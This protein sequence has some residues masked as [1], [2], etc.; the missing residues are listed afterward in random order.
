MKLR[1]VDGMD[2][3][4]VQAPIA[5][6]FGVTVEAVKDIGA[7]IDDGDQGKGFLI[8]VMSER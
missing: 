2:E 3:L 7:T 1:R 6:V 8:S 4:F 5:R